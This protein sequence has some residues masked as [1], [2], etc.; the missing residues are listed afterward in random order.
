[1]LSAFDWKITSFL[2]ALANID[3]SLDL[4]AINVEV[5]EPLTVVELLV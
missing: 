5:G 1:M 2:P 3:V 4:V